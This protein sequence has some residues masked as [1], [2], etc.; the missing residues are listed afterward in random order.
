MSGCLVLCLKQGYCGSVTWIMDGKNYIQVLKIF[1]IVQFK[2]RKQIKCSVLVC[3]T[4]S[5]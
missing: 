4:F 2:K 3:V 1:G 5:L